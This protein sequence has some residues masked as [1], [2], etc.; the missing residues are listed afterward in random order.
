MES[1]F[2]DAYR[3]FWVE[4]NENT[5]GEIAPVA[6]LFGAAQSI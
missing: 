1:A 4:E 5:V 2:L 6:A 3:T